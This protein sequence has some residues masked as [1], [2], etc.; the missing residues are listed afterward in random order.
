[1]HKETWHHFVARCDGTKRSI[2]VDGKQVAEDTPGMHNVSLE[3]RF[4]V[5][6]RLSLSGRGGGEDGFRG[7]LSE[8]TASRVAYGCLLIA[9]L[10]ALVALL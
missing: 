5:G 9:L 1:M 8:V 4:Y 6:A 3:S 2:V 10:I 7:A